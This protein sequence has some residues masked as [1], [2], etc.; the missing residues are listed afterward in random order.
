M[1]DSLKTIGIGLIFYLLYLLVVQIIW[2]EKTVLLA[3]ATIFSN[4]V[5]K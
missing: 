5:N 3:L 2:F 1:K 4:Q